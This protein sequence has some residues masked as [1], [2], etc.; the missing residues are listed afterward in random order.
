MTIPLSHRS[1]TIIL[2]IGLAVGSFL[3]GGILVFFSA[4]VLRFFGVPIINHPSMRL[5]L[6]VILLQGITFG[7]VTIL[8]LKARNRSVTFIHVRLPTRHDFVWI[9]GGIVALFAIL[10]ASSALLSTLG[11]E[12]AQNRILQT[13]RQNPLIFLLMVILSFVLIGPGEELM[14]RGLI[15]GT[16][17]EAFSAFPAIVLASL[18]FGLPHFFSLQGSGKLVSIGTVFVLALVLGAAYEQTENLIVPILIHAVFNAVQFGV[19]YV[20][21][22]RDIAIGILS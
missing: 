5:G 21:I 13:G 16:L 6:S 11:I 18:I 4:R 9:F 1:R 22:T 14:F 3:A 2:A 19:A 8:Y 15:Q 17:R 10:V 20:V 7:G 12:S